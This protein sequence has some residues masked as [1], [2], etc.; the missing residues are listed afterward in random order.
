MA[1]GQRVQ[2]DIAGDDDPRAGDRLAPHPRFGQSAH[3]RCRHSVA[4]VFNPVTE[5]P[6]FMITPAPR[7]P[8]PVTI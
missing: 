3:R 2:K 5:D 8:I 1:P 6:C 4:A 7:K